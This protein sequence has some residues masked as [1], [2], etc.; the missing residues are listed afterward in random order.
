MP[1]PRSIP[2]PLCGRGFFKASLPFHLKSCEQKTAN[3]MVPCPYCQ[4][5]HRQVRLSRK[6]L[7]MRDLNG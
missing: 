1:P 4:A 2:C 5:E 7:S 3:L 6:G